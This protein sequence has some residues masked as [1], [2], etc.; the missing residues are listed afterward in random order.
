M[1][2]SALVREERL[3]RVKRVK[4]VKRMGFIENNGFGFARG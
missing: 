4:R 2:S 1:Q 3:R